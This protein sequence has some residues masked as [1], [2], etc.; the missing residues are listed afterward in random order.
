MRCLYLNV[1]TVYFMFHKQII[2][3]HSLI[4]LF[5]IIVF[6]RDPEN[7]ICIKPV[8]CVFVWEKNLRNGKRLKLCWKVL[9]K[10]AL[11]NKL[12]L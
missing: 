4:K 5:K 11:K 12:K 9:N 3:F 1:F 7:K 10:K 6:L 8:L 2:L